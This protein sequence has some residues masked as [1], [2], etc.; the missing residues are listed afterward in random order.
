MSS[1]EYC[2]IFKNIFFI[3]LPV[4]VSVR[5]FFMKKFAES[6]KIFSTKVT[7]ES[8]HFQS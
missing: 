7:T 8:L 5:E 1:C 2:E 3:T 6:E 4:A